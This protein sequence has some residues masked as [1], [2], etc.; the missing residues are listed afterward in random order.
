MGETVRRRLGVAPAARLLWGWGCHGAAAAN[1]G[2]A[3]AAGRSGK[4]GGAFLRDAARREQ[5][6]GFLN[7]EYQK[8]KGG[9][10]C[11]SH[12]HAACD[13]Y[14]ATTAHCHIDLSDLCPICF[15]P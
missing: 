11:T 8:H 3:A 5:S 12:S 14:P 15:P 4:R 13:P 10:S 2:S 9:L 1:A 7:C 6:G